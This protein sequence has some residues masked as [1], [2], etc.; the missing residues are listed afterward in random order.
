[1]KKK[2]KRKQNVRDQTEKYYIKKA[3]KRVLLFPTKLTPPRRMMFRRFWSGHDM[4]VMPWH[5]R[6]YHL[7]MMNMMM[8]V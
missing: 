6:H 8:R 1:M 4:L 3:P 5:N 7:F 2:K